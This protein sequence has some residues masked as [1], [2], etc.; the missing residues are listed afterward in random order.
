MPRLPHNTF[1]FLIAVVAAWSVIG[2]ALVGAQTRP[3]ADPPGPQ[4]GPSAL[5]QSAEW[6]MDVLRLKNGKLRRGYVRTTRDDEID[7]IEVNRNSGRPM[8]LVVMSLDPKS[9]DRVEL[10]LPADRKLLLDRISPLLTHKS[11]VEI[12]AGRMQDVELKEIVRDGV[13]YYI[14]PASWFTLESTADEASTRRCVVR[15]EQ[16]FRAFRHVLPERAKGRS[17]L[18]VLLFGSMEEYRR[19]LAAHGLILDN[20]AY[21]SSA[22][23]TIAA[24]SELV[25]YAERLE[26]VRRENEALR[27]QY[28]AR[29]REINQRLAELAV[30]L[31]EAGFTEDAIESEQ[32]IRKSAWTRQ[33]NDVV[34]EDGASGELAY[35]DRKNADMFEQVAGQMFRR[36]YHEAFHAYLENYAY[37]SSAWHV[38]RWLNEG[39]AQIFENGQ[40]DA[41]DTLRLDAPDRETLAALQSDLLRHPLPLAALLEAEEHAFL[42]THGDPHGSRRHYL[43][44]W[45]LAW[46]LAFD[47]D[48][49]AGERFNEY[50]SPEHSLTSSLARFE[51]LVGQPLPDFDAAWRTEILRTGASK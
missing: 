44:S 34:G 51:A 13:R 47:R 26:Q 39:L 28:E 17:E 14:C 29:N 21:Y 12:E 35:I 11:H 38:P 22:R 18:R 45:G 27:R 50:L 1:S 36:L 48:L 30:K 40:I 7:F 31:R 37:P 49:L 32:K 33:F 4:R 3:A 24:G 15:L 2:P 16:V 6:K 25:R 19:H 5:E 8:N 9:V 41:D 23:N 20:P 43:Y 10:A 46:H 42:H